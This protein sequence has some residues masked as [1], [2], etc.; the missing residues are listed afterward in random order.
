V[1]SVNQLGGIHHGYFLSHEGANNI[2]SALFSFP[3]LADYEQYRTQSRENPDCQAALTYA[4]RT[5]CILSFDRS[6]LRPMFDGIT[7]QEALS[8]R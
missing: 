3:L 2:A 6:F 4:E 5:R 7:V 8:G 1:D